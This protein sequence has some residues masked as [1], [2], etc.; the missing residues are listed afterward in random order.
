VTELVEQIR[1]DRQTTLA[2][3]IRKAGPDVLREAASRDVRREVAQ[4]I[5]TL[6]IRYG[7]NYARFVAEIPDY[8]SLAYELDC[9]EA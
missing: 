6:R 1:T 8:E 5:D 3:R 2:N 4:A 7:W 9:E